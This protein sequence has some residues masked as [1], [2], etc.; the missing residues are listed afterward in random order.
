VEEA[1]GFFHNRACE[2]DAYHQGTL[3][4]ETYVVLL[5]R[6]GRHAEAMANAMQYFP[7]GTH[8]TGFAPTMI[9]LCRAA[10]DYSKLLDH[11]RDRGDLVG[12]AAGL[13]AEREA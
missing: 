11:C 4:C 10:G 12:Y 7:P 6:L 9:E 8:T 1:L 3:A 2:V 13:L 5:S